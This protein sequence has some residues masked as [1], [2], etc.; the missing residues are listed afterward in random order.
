MNAN[1]MVLSPRMPLCKVK[2]VRQCLLIEPNIWVVVDVCVQDIYGQDNTPDAN[3]WI[4]GGVPMVCRMLPSGCLIQDTNDGYCKV[5]TP[6]VYTFSRNVQIHPLMS[7]PAC[8]Y[9]R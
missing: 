2:F 3:T 4:N 9:F 7:C 6:P 5:H 1:M 8:T